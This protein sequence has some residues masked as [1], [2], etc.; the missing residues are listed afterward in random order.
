MIVGKCLPLSINHG[1]VS[2]NTNPVGGEYLW[3]TIATVSCNSGYE[4]EGPITTPCTTE[5]D[6]TRG[7]WSG[8][9]P[10]TWRPPTTRCNKG[11]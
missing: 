5:H 7:R 11:K 4:R 1:S 8:P 6:A 3:N 9:P 10:D 2:Y